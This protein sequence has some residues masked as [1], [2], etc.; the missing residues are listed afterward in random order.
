MIRKTLLSL[1]L[2]GVILLPDIGSAQYAGNY[3][4]TGVH[5]VYNYIVREMSN[6]LD[7]SLY[8]GYS[9][10]AYWPSQASALFAWPLL[11]Y[12]V[13]DT[14]LVTVSLPLPIYL[15]FHLLLVH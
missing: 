3:D 12:D 6:S 8:G 5:N 1:T 4:L 9:V 14:V 10:T 15:Q 2:V 11:T 13:G 7:D